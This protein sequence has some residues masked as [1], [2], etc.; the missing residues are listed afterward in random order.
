MTTKY[1]K[2]LITIT[3]VAVGFASVA[4]MTWMGWVS[5]ST[6]EHGKDISK[7]QQWQEDYGRKIDW[8]VEKNGAN[9]EAIRMFYTPTNLTQK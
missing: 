2:G 1:K 5:S 3:S 7:I 4:S 9:P 6:I 8:L